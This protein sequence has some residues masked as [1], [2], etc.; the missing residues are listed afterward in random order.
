MKNGD[1]DGVTY[2][3]FCTCPLTGDLRSSACVCGCVVNGVSTTAA[4]RVLNECKHII[5]PFTSWACIL[6][7]HTQ[8]TKALSIR[9]GTPHA[10]LK[11]WVHGI[12][13]YS[14]II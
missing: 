2:G 1:H 11:V 7:V 8:L 4:T 10:V 9:A 6:H 3:C 12:Y 5:I 14:Q 13:S